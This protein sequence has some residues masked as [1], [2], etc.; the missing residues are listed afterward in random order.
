MKRCQL[1]QLWARDD[2]DVCEFCDQPFAP[3]A[4]APLAP[5]APSGSPTC[6]PKD[7]AGVV[8]T[9][10][11]LRQLAKVHSPSLPC[12]PGTSASSIILHAIYDDA[13]TGWHASTIMCSIRRVTPINGPP[14]V[15]SFSSG[16][17]P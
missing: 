10:E 1:C 13:M 12:N 5:P 8:M 17:K 16:F 14:T 15:R 6:I 7:E 3:V 2:T 4:A 11:I 9:P